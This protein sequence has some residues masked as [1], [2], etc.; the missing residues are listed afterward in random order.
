[1]KL[2]AKT[3]SV[4]AL[5]LTAFL[6]KSFS[7]EKTMSGRVHT[8]NGIGIAGALVQ[9]TPS[10]KSAITD[11]IG[12]YTIIVKESD[13]SLSVSSIG[14]ISQ[15]FH[16]AGLQNFDFALLDDPKSLTEVIVTAYGIKKE[17]KKI[18]YAVQELKGADLVKARD[19]NP[20]NS[21]IG[22]IAGLSVGTSPEMLGRPELVL[23]GSKDLLFVIDGVPVNTDT[24]NISPDDIESYSVLKGANASALY[25][26]RGING[27][28]IITTKRG[29]KSKKGWQVEV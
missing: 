8:K 23:R 19:D 16:L 28:I 13:K 21:L 1:M 4:T 9:A 2:F 7:Q 17:T 10:K 27:A 5:L 14:F 11:S 3:L 24:W 25:G 18:G 26:F 20:I 6:T 29:T 15:S 22:K 12:H